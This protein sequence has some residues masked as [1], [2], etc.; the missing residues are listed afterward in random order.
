VTTI[1]TTTA[2]LKV[3]GMEEGGPVVRGTLDVTAAR[4]ALKEWA[5]E[6]VKS[7][8]TNLY[9]TPAEIPVWADTA[10]VSRVGLFRWNPCHLRNCYGDGDHIGHLDYVD[11]PGPG[12]WQGVLFR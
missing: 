5:T 10:E 9:V 3:T 4:E 11:Q 2:A 6:D 1:F 12:V 7:S 8:L